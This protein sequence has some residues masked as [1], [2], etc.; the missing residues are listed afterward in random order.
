M[1]GNW[2]KSIAQLLASS[3]KFNKIRGIFK[4]KPQEKLITKEEAT[5][6]KNKLIYI[7]QY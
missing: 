2:E 4:L 1:V 6:Y 7:L 3:R 5:S